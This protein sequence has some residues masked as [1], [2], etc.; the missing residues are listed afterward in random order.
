MILLLPVDNEKS[1]TKNMLK[2]IYNFKTQTMVTHNAKK[3]FLHPGFYIL[4]FRHE[5]SLSRIS[6]HGLTV[7][8][9][10]GE[11]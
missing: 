6:K 1:N 3:A 9:S 4:Y 8:K 10:G 11:D 5:L 7:H 2:K